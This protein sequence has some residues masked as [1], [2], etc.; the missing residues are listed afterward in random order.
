MKS[1]IWIYHDLEILVYLCCQV[2]CSKLYV[3][4]KKKRYFVILEGLFGGDWEGLN[5]QQVK[6]PSQSLP[7]PHNP[8]VEVINRTSS[9]WR[10][11]CSHINSIFV[12]C[13]L[14]ATWPLLE[15]KMQSLYL[16][17]SLA[18]QLIVFFF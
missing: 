9:E 3:K 11:L 15:V 4:R 13:L 14:E 12:D 1:S 6:I 16:S 5:P 7:I 10:I 17:I 8:L 18:L 2:F